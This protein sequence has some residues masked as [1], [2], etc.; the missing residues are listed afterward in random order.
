MDKNPSTT[1]ACL[2][3]RRLFQPLS[4]YSPSMAVEDHPLTPG[5]LVG[6]LNPE[7]TLSEHP[8]TRAGLWIQRLL[9]PVI[10]G[11]LRGPWMTCR[12]TISGE[13]EV[14]TP[15]GSELGHQSNASLK[16]RPGKR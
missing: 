8:M 1:E 12:F 9:A 16:P 3:L 13:K 6:K 7:A 10:L 11:F 5:P 2:D 14:I 15:A 4:C